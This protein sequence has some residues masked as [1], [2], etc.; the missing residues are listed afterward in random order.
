MMVVVVMMVM[1]TIRSRSDFCWSRL[2][3]RF[4]CMRA[5]ECMCESDVRAGCVPNAPVT[6]SLRTNRKWEMCFVI[7]LLM[8]C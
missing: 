8:W 3:A 7:L 4:V 5:R 2:P 1:V 6:L